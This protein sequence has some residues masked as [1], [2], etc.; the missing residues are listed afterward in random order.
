MNDEDR[1]KLEDFVAYIKIIQLSYFEQYFIGVSF[2]DKNLT[3]AVVDRFKHVGI[4]LVFVYLEFV[5]INYSI[6]YY[7]AEEK[8]FRALPENEQQ[9]IEEINSSIELICEAIYEMLHHISLLIQ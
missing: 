3:E 7:K 2:A 4:N 1:I 8:V 6:N 5:F 9:E